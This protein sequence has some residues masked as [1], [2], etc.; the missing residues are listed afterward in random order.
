MQMTQTDR[1]WRAYAQTV[2][3]AETSAYWEGWKQKK[4]QKQQTTSL[5]RSLT[6]GEIHSNICFGFGTRMQNSDFLERMFRSLTLSPRPVP[7]VQSRKKKHLALGLN[8]EMLAHRF[9]FH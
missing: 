2:S 8:N 5:I 3:E 4:I 9:T 7:S 1:L 6:V